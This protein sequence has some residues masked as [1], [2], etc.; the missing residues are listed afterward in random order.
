MRPL[1]LTVSAFGPYA[2]VEEIPFSRLGSRG[3]YLITGDTGAGK[4]F[5]FDAIVFALYG[6]ASGNAREAAM[7]RS[8]YAKEDTPTYVT[9]RFLYHDNEYAI[10]RSPEYLRPSKRG[11]GMTQS[12]AEATLTYPDGHIVTKSKDVTRAVEELLGI[13]K[14]QFT[15][16]AMIAQGDFLRLLYAKTEDRGKIFREIFHTRA[17]QLLQE[18]LKEESGVLRSRCEQYEQ[19]I[20]QYADGILWETDRVA[21]S[22]TEGEQEETEAPG[23]LRGPKKAVESVDVEGI[24]EYLLATLSCQKRKLEEITGQ[25]SKLEEKI[26]QSNQMIGKAQMR[27]K[28]REELQDAEALLEVLTPQLSELKKVL[29][30]QEGKQKQIDLLQRKIAAQEEKLKDYDEVDRLFL[31]TQEK[32]QEIGERKEQLHRQKAEREK[33]SERGKTVEERLL[34]LN[35]IKLREAGVKEEKRRLEEQSERWQKLADDLQRTEQLYKK[36]LDRQR[37]YRQAAQEHAEYQS[38]FEQLQQRYLDEQA[39]VLAEDLEEGM[40]C[41]VCGSTHHPQLAHRP[42]DAPDKEAVARAKKAWEKSNQK[43]QEHSAQAG[44]AGG[45]YSS[46]LQALAS[47]FCTW[48]LIED[49]SPSAPLEEVWESCKKADPA[50]RQSLKDV[51]REIRELE[52]KEERIREQKKEKEE[53]DKKLPKIKEQLEEL[54]ERIKDSEARLMQLE[55]EKKMSLRQWQEGKERLP[56]PN[57]EE[58]KE[59]AEN[60]REYMEALRQALATARESFQ[61]KEREYQD[62]RQNRKT[63]MKQLE[64][65]VTEI[66]LDSFRARRE[67][68]VER[69]NDCRNQQSELSMRYETNRKIKEKL[70]KQGVAMQETFERYR[71]VC[72]LS[73]TINGNLAGKDKIMLE[74]YVQMQYFDRIIDRANTRFMVMSSGQY[75]L[76][77][78]VQANN[79][80]S[81]SGLEL[82]VVD[83]YNGSLRSVKTLS[84][85]EAFLASLSLALGLS[86]EIQSESGGIALDTM[87]VDEGFGSLDETALKQALDALC[88]LS[89]GSRLVGII[90]HVSELQERIGQKI[91]VVKEVSGKS[92]V[93]I[94]TE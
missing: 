11:G 26:E 91:V 34:Q 32:E 75:E 41:P 90:S 36:L 62:A 15:Q 78:S 56:Y 59:Q 83:H 1:H 47:A 43:M 19:S 44:A 67:E 4:T 7:F 20:R 8:K 28:M 29:E 27:C 81:Q 68:L 6:E 10:T 55:T 50:L 53:C 82:D 9:L 12:R 30:E 69:K 93:Q 21:A 85:G 52:G 71:M 89:D 51:Q 37:Q 54:D 84:G 61:K 16:I 74:T 72:E 64:E 33:L 65:D 88:D 45:E 17:Y 57:K 63:L 79:M 24:R 40:R 39:G 14:N 86:D 38:D 92:H 18:K 77:R 80:K 2:D 46:A 5:L 66:D 3:V 49:A 70:D 13:D 23:I 25:L 76:K 35:D 48:K 87:F 94:V 60:D 22:D 73:N 42:K 31:Q 58:A